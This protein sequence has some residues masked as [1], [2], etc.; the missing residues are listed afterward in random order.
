MFRYRSLG[1]EKG[2][3]VITDTP[4]SATVLF[5]FGFGLVLVQLVL[6]FALVKV[7]GGFPACQLKFVPLLLIMGWGSNPPVFSCA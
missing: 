2:V 4:C 6:V 5:W 7:V 1:S 3:R